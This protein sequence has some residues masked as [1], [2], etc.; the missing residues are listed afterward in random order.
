MYT[1]NFINGKYMN[2]TL[3]NPPSVSIYFSTA[4]VRTLVQSCWGEKILLPVFT[5]LLTWVEYTLG[6]YFLKV[7]SPTP[8]IFAF[9]GFLD[10]YK[11]YFLRF[12]C[13]C[14]ARRHIGGILSLVLNPIASAI[15]YWGVAFVRH[16]LFGYHSF[17]WF[18]IWFNAEV[19]TKL[20]LRRAWLACIWHP[21]YFGFALL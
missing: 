10:M 5:W 9:T 13:V 1:I 3:G 18:T 20:P 7:R 21:L 15:L 12:R 2:P 6:F 16:I 19:S 14:C 11:L 8:S 4:L 17:Y